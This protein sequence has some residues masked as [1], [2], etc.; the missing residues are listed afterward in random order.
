MCFL[1][2]YVG[3][4]A[5]PCLALGAFAAI[6]RRLRLPVVAATALIGGLFGLAWGWFWAHTHEDIRF[7]FNMVPATLG[8]EITRAA[9]DLMNPRYSPS[10]TSPYIDLTPWFSRLPQVEV[11]VSV[12]FWTMAGL[13]VGYLV[14]RWSAREVQRQRH[15]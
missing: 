6:M 1:P 15:P 7:Y 14:R 10:P 8:Q 12:V 11:I 5:V 9:Q 13:I 4:T 2:F 3:S